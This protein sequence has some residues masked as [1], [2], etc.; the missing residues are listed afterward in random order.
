MKKIKRNPFLGFFIL[1]ILLFSIWAVFALTMINPYL[2]KYFVGYTVGKLCVWEIIA[3]S[4]SSLLAYLTLKKW[5]IHWIKDEH[6]T[7]ITIPKPIVIGFIAYI[8]I[9]SIVGA[10]QY[11]LFAYTG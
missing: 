11:Y 6:Q 10:W 7:Q 8:F 1:T 3:L 9:M 4:L 5:P 2:S